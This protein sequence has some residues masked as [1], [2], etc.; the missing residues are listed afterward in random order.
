M[1]ET[2][3]RD[4]LN[5]EVWFSKQTDMHLRVDR[6]THT[7]FCTLTNRDSRRA[8][9]SKHVR[10]ND[11]EQATKGNKQMLGTSNFEMSMFQAAQYFRS[12]P[13]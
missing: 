8:I 5:V 6:K 13:G 2:N 4:P 12:R 7:N 1:A 9:F 10:L 11:E 3:N